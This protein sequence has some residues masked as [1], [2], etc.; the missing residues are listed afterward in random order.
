MSLVVSVAAIWYSRMAAQASQDVAVV[1][2][3]R[4]RR[5]E[6]VSQSAKLLM[7]E[8]YDL[9]QIRNLGEHTAR[10][11]TLTYDGLLFRTVMEDD[12]RGLEIKPGEVLELMPFIDWDHPRNHHHKEDHRIRGGKM[13]VPSFPLTLSW[14]DGWSTAGAPTPRAQGRG[15]TTSDRGRLIARDR[16]DSENG[17]ALPDLSSAWSAAL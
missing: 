16:Q 1:E 2:G 11:L 13:G 17:R 14:V 5:E 6:A 4:H 12:D 7:F 15:A 3:E 10:N 9:V 8:A